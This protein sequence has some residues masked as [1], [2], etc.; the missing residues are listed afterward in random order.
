MESSVFNPNCNTS[1]NHLTNKE[2]AEIAYNALQQ[3]KMNKA[4]ND[5]AEFN[6][7]KTNICDKAR[8]RRNRNV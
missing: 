5:T 1:S 2:K 7:Y 6:S 3:R 4:R 8:K